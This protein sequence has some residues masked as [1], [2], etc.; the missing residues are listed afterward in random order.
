MR[1]LVR[2]LVE[3]INSADS[4]AV[5]SLPFAP[6][7]AKHGFV[8]IGRQVLASVVAM[9]AY[10]RDDRYMADGI[11]EWMCCYLGIVRT[12]DANVS[13]EQHSLDLAVT[14]LL[15]EAGPGVD[16]S[17]DS[18]TRLATA[19][20]LLASAPQLAVLTA[21]H[22]SP[23]PRGY[24]AVFSLHVNGNHFVVVILTPD[25]AT[26]RTGTCMIL[27]SLA[28]PDRFRAQRD[29]A[30]EHIRCV[31]SAFYNGRQRHTPD[32]WVD[33]R[34]I[35][36]RSP[37]QPDGTSCAL[38]A[39]FSMMLFHLDLLDD[40]YL[41]SVLNQYGA[42]GGRRLV[43]ALILSGGVYSDALWRRYMLR[44]TL[45]HDEAVRECSTVEMSLQ[46]WTP[47][48][49]AQMFVE[50]VQQSRNYRIMTPTRVCTDHSPIRAVFQ[51]FD[52]ELSTLT[53]LQAMAP[54][55]PP[56]PGADDDCVIISHTT[57]AERAAAGEARVFTASQEEVQAVSHLL[58]PTSSD[59]VGEE[60]LWV[61]G[62]V[63]LDVDDVSNVGSVDVDT[64][65]E[66]ISG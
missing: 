39:S 32:N 1:P 26:G 11:I 20:T 60:L 3:V 48:R 43:A 2:F 5:F 42:D 21:A 13:I 31:A 66:D 45:T 14:A 58:Q 52:N 34:L 47:E 49:L 36:Q 18:P 7:L 29:E 37:Q 59:M 22:H 15:V 25:S 35:A 46:S 38:Y 54:Y 6:M 17:P 57:A 23:R 40:E 27:D 4:D 30:R 51:N 28:V 9:L 19:A 44:D 61:S 10:T 16:V 50:R 33:F 41:R 63:V 56:P 12:V 65:P 55:I 62:E 53:S 64:E 24:T 8:V